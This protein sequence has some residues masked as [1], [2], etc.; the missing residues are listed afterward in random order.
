M[1]IFQDANSH[2]AFQK[3][4]Q[5]RPIFTLQKQSNLGLC[6][7]TRHFLQAASYRNFRTF[8]SQHILSVRENS[9]KHYVMIFLGV[10]QINRTMSRF[11]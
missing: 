8:T 6:C 5:G 3:S 9:E 10:K 1:L 7:L 4:K 2:N 11:E